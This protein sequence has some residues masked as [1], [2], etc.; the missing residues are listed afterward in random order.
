MAGIGCWYNS[1]WV[2]PK[3]VFGQIK[4]LM[5]DGFNPILLMGTLARPG[6]AWYVFNTQTPS[7][8]N[9]NKIDNINI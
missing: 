9:T 6:Y 4:V 2:F 7:M 8:Y 5:D 3:D 1:T